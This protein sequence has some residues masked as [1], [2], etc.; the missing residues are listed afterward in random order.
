MKF[1]TENL[2]TPED[3]LV[4]C[5]LKFNTRWMVVQR[6]VLVKHIRMMYKNPS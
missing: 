4:V 1:V 6:N 3:F 5:S 2:S